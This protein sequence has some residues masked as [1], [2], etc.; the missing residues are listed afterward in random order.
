MNEIYKRYRDRLEQ[1]IGFL[2]DKPE[3]NPD[4]T[5]RALWQAAS[6]EP[7]SLERAAAQELPPL[8]AQ[9]T[10]ALESLLARRLAGEPLAHI[11][12]RQHFMGLEMLAGPEALV[13]RKETEL[14]ANAALRLAR[15]LTAAESPITVLDV[16]T[17][18]GNLALT[19]AHNLP[20]ARVFAADISESAIALARRN[21]SHLGLQ[22]RVEFRTGDLLQP[23]A[24]P[25]FLGQVHLLVCN[26]PYITSTRVGQMPAEISQREPRLAFDGGPFGISIVGRLLTE[27]P[28]WLRPGGWLAFEV[29]LGQGEL[30]LKRMK[31]SGSFREIEPVPD[32]S[33]AVRGL[34]AQR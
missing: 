2:P 30:L 31:S 8:T 21:A 5:L 26:P 1:G 6:G 17:G 15:G 22:D 28:R 13:P 34:V 23:F 32:S 33:G 12:G 27:A 20:G 29:G 25:E 7:M 4:S 9:S 16:C 11:T 18:S 14:L 3:E 24:T 10:A 19:L